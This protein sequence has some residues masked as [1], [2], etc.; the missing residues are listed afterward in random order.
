M[1]TWI[2][3][4]LY[5]LGIFF[6]KKRNGRPELTSIIAAT[7]ST[8]HADEVAKKALNG[9]KSGCFIVT[10]NVIG[11]LL[12]IATAGLS[13][14]RSYLMAFFEVISSS[15]V[16]FCCPKLKKLRLSGT[17]VLPVFVMRLF[18][19]K[20]LKVLCALNCPSLEEDTT[21]YTKS[22][23]HGKIMLSS[24][25]DTFKELSLMFPDT[26]NDRDI[27]SDWRAKSEKRDADLDEFV[28]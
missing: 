5:T 7:S 8:M 24:F 1:I 16:R 10:C 4:T 2:L 23:C 11:S 20:G 17:D 14:Q 25:R 12:S 13:P 3:T 9:I 28:T 6:Y 15:I 22:S 19:I 21:V 18:S 26:M 27:F